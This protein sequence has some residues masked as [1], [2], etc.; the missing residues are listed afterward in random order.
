[1][2]IIENFIVIKISWN[3]YRDTDLADSVSLITEIYTSFFFFY[4]SMWIIMSFFTKLYEMWEK[5]NA[6]C[7]LHNL[8]SISSVWYEFCFFPAVTMVCLFYVYLSF[9]LHSFYNLA[10]NFSD[11]NM[12]V[13]T[14]VFFVDM[15]DF[16]EYSFCKVL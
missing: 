15:Q 2:K 6:K 7:K 4:K 5:S 3:F 16:Y 11:K 8:C 9:E 12:L 14:R 10:E 1:M 13:P